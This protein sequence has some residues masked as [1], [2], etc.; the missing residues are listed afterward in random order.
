MF[1]VPKDQIPW[2]IY[3][4]HS[5]VAILRIDTSLSHP[6]LVPILVIDIVPLYYTRKHSGR[7]LMCFIFLKTL[8]DLSRIYMLLS[9]KELELNLQ[10]SFVMED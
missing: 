4:A 3:P 10:G 6:V 2:R 5:K 7:K 8:K 9:D 1:Y